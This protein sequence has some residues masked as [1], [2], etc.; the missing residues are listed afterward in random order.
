MF[1]GDDTVIS[2]FSSV[3]VICGVSGGLADSGVVLVCVK[4]ATF[5]VC[6][7]RLFLCGLDL[8]LPDLVGLQGSMLSLG[9]RGLV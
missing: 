1:S 4:F 9:G 5:F 8:S 6:Y 3:A 7:V 2:L